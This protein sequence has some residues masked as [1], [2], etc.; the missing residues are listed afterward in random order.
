MYLK[1]W[2]EEEYVFSE[3]AERRRSVQVSVKGT[4]K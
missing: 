3:S 4:R 2:E 1:S